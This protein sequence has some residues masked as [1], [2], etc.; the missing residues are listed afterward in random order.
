MGIFKEAID[1]L[2]V[3]PEIR[4]TLGKMAFESS[5]LDLIKRA[6]EEMGLQ[7]Q[8]PVW[9]GI[10][11]VAHLGIPSKKVAIA[12]IY[13]DQIDSCNKKIESW[14]NYGWSYIP[15]TRRAIRGRG[16]DGIKND[17]AEVIGN[18]RKKKSGRKA[19]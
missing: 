5:E 3:P 7:Y 11:S 6:C 8:S 12:L 15:I 17:L 1:M 10:D 9:I 4:R 2:S 18:L 16:F 14:G 13:A 19:N